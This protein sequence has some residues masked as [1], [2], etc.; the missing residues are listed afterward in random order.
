MSFTVGSLEL[1][2]M[3]FF[4]RGFIVFYLFIHSFYGISMSLEWLFLFFFFSFLLFF[5]V[6]LFLFYFI[7][8]LFV[9]ET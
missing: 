5:Y 1:I 7:F 3:I 9:M 8:S 2:L 4:N 6:V